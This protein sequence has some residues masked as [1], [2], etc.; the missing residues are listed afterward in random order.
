MTPS[1]PQV[2]LLSGPPGAGKDAVTKALGKHGGSFRLFPRL[3]AGPG[4]T[5]GYRMISEERLH[6]LGKDGDLAQLQARYG[7]LYAVDFGRL[8]AMV[9]AGYVPVV[10]VGRRR[11]LAGLQAVPFDTAS[12]L[13]WVSR[14][15]SERRVADRAGQARGKEWEE[16][17]DE[18][19][20]SP[21]TEDFDAVYDSDAMSAA[22]IAERIASSWPYLSGST[23][24][25]P[26]E[27][28]IRRSARR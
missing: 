28:A 9:N 5:A 21:L 10:H 3:K 6:G 17:R 15:Q 25:E 11:N 8:Q 4:R 24:F 12:V 18:L 13:V 1:A 2:L 14:E 26:V 27:R 22:E 20:A 7:N 16:E 23:D 19:K